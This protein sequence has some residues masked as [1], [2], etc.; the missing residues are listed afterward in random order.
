MEPGE[1]SKPCL[2]ATVLSLASNEALSENEVLSENDYIKRTA[3]LLFLV[4]T[5]AFA[6]LITFQWIWQH[7]FQML[8][9][10]CYGN[11]NQPSPNYC[12]QTQL[13]LSL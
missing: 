8:G 10:E 5:D 9:S 2:R 3:Y 4:I 6:P 1:R 12:H 11:T 7:S 13:K